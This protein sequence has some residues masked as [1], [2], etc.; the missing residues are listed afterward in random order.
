MTAE[1]AINIMTANTETGS[2]TYIFGTTEIE[3]P[4]VDFSNIEYGVYILTIITTTEGTI[5]V[6]QY[7]AADV[8]IPEV[9]VYLDDD[10]TNIINFHNFYP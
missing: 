10:D 7:M 2:S 4:D 5:T 3:Q 9:E 8:N 6:G 1:Q